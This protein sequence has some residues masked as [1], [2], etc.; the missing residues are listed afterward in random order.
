MTQ[1]RRHNCTIDDRFVYSEDL[2]VEMVYEYRGGASWH[3]RAC[4]VASKMYGEVCIYEATMDVTDINEMLR[5]HR[6]QVD[7][8]LTRLATLVS[9]KTKTE[10]MR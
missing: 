10:E 5:Y 7:E 6:R 9:V 4:L 2:V 1:E 3:C 8:I